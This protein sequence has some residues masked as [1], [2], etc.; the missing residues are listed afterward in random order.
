MSDSTLFKIWPTVVLRKKFPDHDSAKPGLLKFVREYMEKDLEGR[1]AN[2]NR[3]LYESRD[4]IFKTHFDSDGSIRSLANFLAQ[5]IAEVA[6]EANMKLWQREAV[7]VKNLSVNITASW[8]INYL[9]GGNVEPHLHGNC[10]WACAYYLQMGPT[11]NPQDGATYLINPTN[12][13]DSA[14]LG[15]R[16]AREAC[17]FFHAVEGYALFFPSHLVHGSFP[18]SGDQPRII[19][20]CNGKLEIQPPAA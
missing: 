9:A 16:Y 2:E 14:D 12:K 7:E 3:G 1:K 20:S 13:S 15:S 18:Y 19:F 5:S 8:F 17:R 4:D 10:S 11:E 6:A